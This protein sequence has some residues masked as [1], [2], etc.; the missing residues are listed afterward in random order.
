MMNVEI[1]EQLEH[2]F[3]G[4]DIMK[5]DVQLIFVILDDSDDDIYHDVKDIAGKFGFKTQCY[6]ANNVHR[7]ESFRD[8]LHKEFIK[9]LNGV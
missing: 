3:E 2:A 1:I 9:K 5:Q 7:M 4:L 8:N 6:R